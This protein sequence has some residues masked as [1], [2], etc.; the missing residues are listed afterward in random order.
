MRT[1]VAYAGL[2]AFTLLG[3]QAANAQTATQDIDIT[4][5]VLKACTVNNAP[6]GTAGSATIPVSAAGAVSTT[7]ITPTGS[8]FAN[9]ACNAPS[10]L[11]LTSLS[12]G[13]K[14]ATTPGSGFTNIIDYQATATWNSVTASIDT[15]TVAGATGSEAGT[16]QSV[17][18]SNSGNLTVSI[19]PLANSLPLVTGSYSDT[20]RVTLTPQ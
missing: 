8:P 15:S 20:L 3:T 5:N 6:T 10:T 1:K 9:V 19:T 16:A 17:A 2:V 11:Q 7:A 13:V 18:T 12:G 14:N 4:A